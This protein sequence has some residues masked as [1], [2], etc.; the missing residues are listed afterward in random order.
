M[1]RLPNEPSHP[2]FRP[3]L[4]GCVS[5]DRRLARAMN[6][7]YQ[8]VLYTIAAYLW[9]S[10][11]VESCDGVLSETFDS[12]AREEIEH[13]R[14]LGELIHAL[15]ATPALR[16]QVRIDPERYRA[17]SKEN[18]CASLLRDAI[19]DEKY[20]IDCY[21]TLLGQTDDRVVRSILSHLLSE[22]HRHA[23]QLQKKLS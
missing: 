17:D 7:C 16:K 18:C 6:E 11:V 13:F 2:P 23:E 19:R 8:N 1:N 9:R 14:L 10:L 21:Q 20:M 5:C 12:L 4:D 22:E 15:G 3:K